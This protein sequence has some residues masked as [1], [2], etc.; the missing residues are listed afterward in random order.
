MNR[1][2]IDFMAMTN[3]NYC[4]INTAVFR[5]ADGGEI[6]FDRDETIYT[7]NNGVLEMRWNSIYAW[8]GDEQDYSV[9]PEDLDG[10]KFVRFEL[11][12]DVD[13]DYYVE[14]VEWEYGTI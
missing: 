4:A 3:K 6:V 7:I 2:T 10:L 11:E 5:N 8:N 9:T 14:D 1:T 12:D 13:A